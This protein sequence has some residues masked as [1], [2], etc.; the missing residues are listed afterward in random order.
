MITL[1]KPQHINYG[2]LNEIISATVNNLKLVEQFIKL[3][4]GF[5]NKTL[6]NNEKANIH[7]N[8]FEVTIKNKKE[9]ILLEYHKYTQRFEKLIQYFKN[10][11]DSIVNQ[12][13]TSEVLKFFLLDNN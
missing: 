5:L 1:K 7:N 6:K 2:K 10:G 11:S 13:S 4:E 9:S 8:N 3:Y 12:I